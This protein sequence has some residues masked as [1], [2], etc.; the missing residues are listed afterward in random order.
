MN[1][2][3]SEDSSPNNRVFRLGT[4]PDKM[5]R[6]GQFQKTNWAHEHRSLLL[7]TLDLS[8]TTD[9]SSQSRTIGTGFIAQQGG[10]YFCHLTIEIRGLFSM[11]C[12]LAS[13]C[14]ADQVRIQYRFTCTCSSLHG[15]IRIFLI[16]TSVP[17]FKH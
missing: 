2:S 15:R 8:V 11:G 14:G 16:R 10:L 17:F 1:Y 3:V 5:S 6:G 13:C 12:P 4:A 7:T 9:L